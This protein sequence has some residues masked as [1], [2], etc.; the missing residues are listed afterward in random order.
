MN[1]TRELLL[2]AK[3]TT[4]TGT[5]LQALR[6]AVQVG[7]RTF[8]D[9][10]RIWNEH[11]ESEFVTRQG[12]ERMRELFEGFAA[13]TAALCEKIEYAHAIIVVEDE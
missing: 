8:Q 9:D 1:A 11:G 5:D 10:A 12:A 4:L 2:G 7:L 13:A 3:T 6:H